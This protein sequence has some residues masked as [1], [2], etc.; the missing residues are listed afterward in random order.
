[1]IALARAITLAGNQTRLAR[2]IGVSPPAITRWLDGTATIPLE[3][4]PKVV[5]FAQDP[6][7][8]PY[9]LRPDQRSNWGLLLQQLAAC[10]VGVL[11][12]FNEGETPP[13]NGARG[14][15]DIE[16]TV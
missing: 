16:T 1:V 4:V 13:R 11:Y 12:A 5:A 14:A 7:V 3:I 2:A 15:T 9:T 8:S 10:H 6:K